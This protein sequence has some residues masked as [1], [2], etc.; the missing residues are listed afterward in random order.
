MSIFRRTVH[1]VEA[2]GSTFSTLQT[3]YLRLTDGD[4]N[5]ATVSHRTQEQLDIEE[6][7][8]IMDTR[9]QEIID[10]PGTQGKL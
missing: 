4:A 9:G 8:I 2:V 7:V 5:V 3:I 6:P 1:L 10:G